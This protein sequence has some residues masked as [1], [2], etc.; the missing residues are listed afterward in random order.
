MRTLLSFSLCLTL[1]LSA[2]QRDVAVKPVSGRATDAS[3]PALKTATAAALT[4]TTE[5]FETGTKGAYAD[6]TVTL[7]TGVWDF[8]DALIG[9]LSTDHKDGAQCARIRNTGTVTMEFD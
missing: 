1:F 3:S 9:N 2:C 6:G 7:S 5:N 8:N 4:V